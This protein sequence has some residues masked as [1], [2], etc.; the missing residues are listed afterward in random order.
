MHNISLEFF[1]R[2]LFLEAL[3]SFFSFIYFYLSFFPFLCCCYS[4]GR[5]SPDRARGQTMQGT[6]PMPFRWN[7]SALTAF[8]Q[9]QRSNKLPFNLDRKENFPTGRQRVSGSTKRTNWQ[10][11]IFPIPFATTASLRWEKAKR[12][13]TPEV[14]LFAMWHVSSR[15]EMAG[16]NR[17]GIS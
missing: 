4:Y 17:E 8:G 14:S 7:P 2:F 12:L 13:P 3:V 15:A 10:G 11:D 1:L 9:S 5:G 16:I 6:Q